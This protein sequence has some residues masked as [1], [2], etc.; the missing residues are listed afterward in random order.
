VS[1]LSLAGDAWS[2]VVAGLRMRSD[3]GYH[4]DGSPA[5]V[6]TVTGAGRR[7][8]MSRKVAGYGHYFDDLLLFQKVQPG[9]PLSAAWQGRVGHAWLGV[10]G[11]PDSADYASGPP[12]LQIGD[13]PG[14]PGYVTV[15]TSG[16]GLQAVDPSESDG[17]ALTFLQIP[18]FGS[19]DIWDVNVVRQ[20]GEDW[21][22]Y[23]AT[24]Y[25]PL[26]S[27]P[28]L[29]AGPQA[30]AI[31]SDGYAEWRR[32]PAAAQLTIGAGTAWHLYGAEMN[33][34]DGG[35]TFP[36]TDTAPA[37]AYLLLF[38]PAGTSPTVTVTPAN[39]DRA[40]W[41]A[42][43]AGQHRAAALHFTLPVRRA[44]VGPQLQDIASV[45]R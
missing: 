35:S 13:V 39:A 33:V 25:R 4:V 22:R 5:S 16:Y 17:A 41:H 42:G 37:G 8:L 28:E 19:R 2:P 31:G 11:R 45:L 29:A 32:L 24:L 3:G 6:R 30:V 14:L 23:A 10:T 38:A 7:Y 1:L 43:A 40:A 12:V 18:G 20:G 9:A 15:A 27:V 44:V 34:L 36:A 21:M 26:D